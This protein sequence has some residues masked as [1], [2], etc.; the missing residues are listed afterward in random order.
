[1]KGEGAA[2]PPLL[3]GAF[4]SESEGKGAIRP[5]F[6]TSGWL[7]V[8]V[9]DWFVSPVLPAPTGTP[10]RYPGIG[11]DAALA[12]ACQF[13]GAVGFFERWSMIVNPRIQWHGMLLAL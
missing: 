3:M 2:R 9:G 13:L 1:M 6:D 7:R 11:P 4:P 12:W 10:W 5:C 8:D